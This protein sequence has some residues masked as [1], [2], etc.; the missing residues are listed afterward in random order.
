MDKA[1][2]NAGAKMAT[3][4]GR[5]VG[6]GASPSACRKPTHFSVPSV[7]WGHAV[8]SSTALILAGTRLSMLDMVVA[9]FW[10]TELWVPGLASQPTSP[11]KA[12]PLTAHFVFQK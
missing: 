7:N 10:F 5:G 11:N 3:F 12:G 8:W 6:L 2:I 9:E 4:L 1:E